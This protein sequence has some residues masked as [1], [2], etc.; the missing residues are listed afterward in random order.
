VGGSAAQA[1]GQGS[2]DIE[3]PAQ[4]CSDADAVVLG[5]VEGELEH[6]EES[7][8]FFDGGGDEAEFSEDFLEFLVGDPAGVG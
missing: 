2:E 7:G 6:A 3:V 8:R 5:S 4:H 1:S